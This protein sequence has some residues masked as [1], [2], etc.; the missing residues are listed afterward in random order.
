VLEAQLARTDDYGAEVT[1]SSSCQ[2]T[3]EEAEQ[4]ARYQASF[5]DEQVDHRLILSLLEHL[6]EEPP[7][8]VLV[9]LP[10]Y[11]DIM[12]LRSASPLHPQAPQTFCIFYSVLRIRISYSICGS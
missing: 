8:A 11:E 2:L 10:G 1:S 6:V 5:D 4:L 9:F 7:G 12:G 3:V